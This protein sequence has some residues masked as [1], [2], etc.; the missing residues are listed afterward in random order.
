MK[1]R[2]AKGPV[3]NFSMFHLWLHRLRVNFLLAFVHL[4]FTVS[5]FRLRGRPEVWHLASYQRRLG[6][7]CLK[8][9]RSSLLSSRRWS[10]VRVRVVTFSFLPS[11]IPHWH[12][13]TW[14]RTELGLFL[15][16]LH[17]EIILSEADCCE[18]PQEQVRWLN[19]HISLFN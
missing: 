18:N 10:G 17:N 7:S 14:R 16:Q 4:V 9:A 3:S 2:L 6:M 11:V 15:L 1:L 12:L 19:E 8:C 13:H 5:V